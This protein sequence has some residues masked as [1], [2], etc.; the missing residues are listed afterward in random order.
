MSSN[1]DGVGRER[2]DHFLRSTNGFFQI[3]RLPL[4]LYF[5]TSSRPQRGFLTTFISGNY[6]M[7]FTILNGIDEII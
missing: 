5:V 3:R 2:S 4:T 7:I 1:G 6:V